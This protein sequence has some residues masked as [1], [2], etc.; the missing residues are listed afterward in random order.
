MV[1]QVRDRF[2]CALSLGIASAVEQH[3]HGAVT[4]GVFCLISTVVTLKD[5]FAIL[6]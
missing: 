2:R 1:K 5:R 4:R 3:V 6:P